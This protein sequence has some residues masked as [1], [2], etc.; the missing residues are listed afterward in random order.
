MI[1]NLFKFSFYFIYIWEN[2]NNKKNYNR[3]QCLNIKIIR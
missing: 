3:K 1:Y 2:I